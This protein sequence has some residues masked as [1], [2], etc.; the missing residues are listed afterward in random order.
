VTD[1]FKQIAI[2]EAELWLGAPPR[3]LPDLGL[4]RAEVGPGALL[5]SGLAGRVAVRLVYLARSGQEIALVQQF[6]GLAGQRLAQVGALQGGRAASADAAARAER[7]VVADEARADLR[8]GA[9]RDAAALE[10]LD[11]P[12]LVRDPDDRVTY[13]WIDAGGYLLSISAQLDAETVRGLADLVR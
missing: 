11:L 10:S 7:P 3:L 5:D 8:A 1:G 12:A 9:D 13:T 6:T 4:L 2:D